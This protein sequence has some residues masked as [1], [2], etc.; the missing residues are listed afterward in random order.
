MVNVFAIEV[1]RTGLQEREIQQLGW[2]YVSAKIESRTRAGY[3][4]GAGKITVKVLAEKGDGRLLGGANHRTGWIS[5]A[6][7][8]VGY[9]A[10]FRFNSRRDDK[11]GPGLFPSLF[12]R[13]GPSRYS[14]AASSKPSM[15]AKSKAQKTKASVNL[16]PYRAN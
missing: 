4:P 7:R 6:H 15:K 8:C 14:R 9:P 5:Q 13:L 10:P 12:A 3:Y 1:T 16:P 11:L 2:P